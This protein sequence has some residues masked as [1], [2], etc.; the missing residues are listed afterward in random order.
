MRPRPVM[1]YLD[2]SCTLAEYACAGEDAVVLKPTTVTFE[3]AATVPIAALTALQGLRDHGQIQPGQ[4][5]LIQGASAVWAPLR[6]RLPNRSELKS[7]PSAAR[8]IWI[9]C[10]PL[11]QT[12]SLINQKDLVLV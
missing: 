3:A 1:K 10:A 5:V 7:L 9:W 6:C 12:V 2:G 11:A 4:K 8:E